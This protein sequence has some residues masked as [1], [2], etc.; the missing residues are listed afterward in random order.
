MK[1]L[2]SI[3]LGLAL[4]VITNVVKADEPAAIITRNQAITAYINAMTLGQNSG[5]N[6]VIDQSAKFSILRQKCNEL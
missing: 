3:F 5:L 1:T 2:K 6:E 4:L